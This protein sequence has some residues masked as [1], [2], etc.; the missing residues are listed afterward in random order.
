MNER[1]YL[2]QLAG[3]ND[4]IV[5]LRARAERAE[6]GWQEAEYECEAL[7]AALAGLSMALRG[8]DMHTHL[9]DCDSCSASV[10]G[11]PVGV[12]LSAAR[13]LLAPEVTE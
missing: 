10:H 8:Y 5:G 3:C 9:R 13:A 7:R 4:E 11:S 2:H 12:A 6:Q 1:D